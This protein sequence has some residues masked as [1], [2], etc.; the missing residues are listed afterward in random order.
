MKGRDQTGLRTVVLRV[1]LTSIAINAGLGIW[2][3]LVDDFGDTQ[4]KVLISS[5]LV[6]GAMLAVLIN[7]APLSRRILWPVPLMAVVGLVSGFVLLLAAVWAEVDS[8]LLGKTLTTAFTLGGAATLSGLLGLLPLRPAHHVLRFVA[9]LLIAVLAATVIGVIWVEGG[10]DA[11]ARVIG[12]QSI[13]VAA[14]TLALPALSRFLPV[15]D[16]VTE[17]GAGRFCPVC[18]AEVD[19][20]LLSGDPVACGRCQRVF[21]VIEQ[22]GS[23]Q[24]ALS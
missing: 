19:D 9:H 12:V 20:Y 23:S 17:L 10:G 1:F 8:A 11:I 7:A 18:G 16:P 15:Q 14:C 3:L 22:R 24:E 2:A 13:L 21:S 5:F 4:E 6:S